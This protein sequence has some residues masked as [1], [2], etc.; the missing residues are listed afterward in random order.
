MRPLRGSRKKASGGKYPGSK[1]LCAFAIDVFIVRLAA[2]QEEEGRK[3]GKHNKREVPTDFASNKSP[4]HAKNVSCMKE[5]EGIQVGHNN[6]ERLRRQR[7][8]EYIKTDTHVM[9]VVQVHC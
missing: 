1:K 4:E 2:E 6:F 3:S 5:R 9:A 7:K 8:Y